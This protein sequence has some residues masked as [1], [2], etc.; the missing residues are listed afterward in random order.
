MS[1]REAWLVK[2]GLNRPLIVMD[3]QSKLHKVIIENTPH[4]KAGKN[5][6]LSNLRP[7]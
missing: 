1:L 7:F 2:S 4:D 3:G 6:K 5:S